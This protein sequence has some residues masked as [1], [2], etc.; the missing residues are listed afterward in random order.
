MPSKIRMIFGIILGF[1]FAI[2][3]VFIFNGFEY[4]GLSLSDHIFVLIGA[5]DTFWSGLYKLIGSGLMVN[6]F[7]EFSL[8]NIALHSFGGILFGEYVWPVIL[9]W[10][11]AGFIEGIM[12]TGWKRGLIGAAIIFAGVFLLWFVIGMFAGADLA[13]LFQYNILITLG[14]L[15]TT[16]ICLIPGGLI[17]GYLTREI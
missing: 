12:L 7:S 5:T 15:V 8:E 6:W 16:L 10:F 3:G 4:R 14:E 9:T 11:M 13:T 17:G 1:L 2:F